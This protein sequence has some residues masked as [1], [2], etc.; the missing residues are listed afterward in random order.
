M[1]STVFFTVQNFL[2][3]KIIE[4]HAKC[5]LKKLAMI[6]YWIEYSILNWK[7]IVEYISLLELLSLFFHKNN[8][9]FDLLV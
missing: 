8:A 4:L 5:A 6:I 7:C 3:V 9:I 2:E 1:V